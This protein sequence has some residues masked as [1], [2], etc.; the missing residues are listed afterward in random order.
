MPVANLDERQ[1]AITI[2]TDGELHFISIVT[3]RQLAAGCEYC[4]DK[5]KL[6]KLL[7]TAIKDFIDDYDSLRP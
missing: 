1:P 4:G 6:I 2:E 7:S 3:I 5:A